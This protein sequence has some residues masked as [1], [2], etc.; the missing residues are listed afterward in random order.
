MARLIL[1]ICVILTFFGCASKWVHYEKAVECHLKDKGG[2]CNPQ[3]EKALKKHPEMRGLNASYGSHLMVLGNRQEA[4][5]Y[6]EIEASLY[7]KESKK[8]INVALGSL[9]EQTNQPKVDSSDVLDK[10]STQI[11]AENENEIMDTEGASQ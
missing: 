5:K 1:N 10:S 2:E 11:S 3:Y 8:S 6:F 7:P 9:E 4:I